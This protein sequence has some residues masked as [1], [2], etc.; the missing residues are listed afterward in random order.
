MNDERK[1]S[2]ERYAEFLRAVCEYLEECGGSATRPEVFSTLQPRLALSEYELSKNNSG[3]ERWRQAIVFAFIGF[4]KAG[5]L[6]RGGGTWRLLDAGREAMHAMSPLE[7]LNSANAKYGEWDDLRIK[8]PDEF[9]SAEDRAQMSGLSDAPG[10]RLWVVGTGT[11][12][13]QWN[14]FR[15]GG[16]VCI[17]FSYGGQQLGDLATMSREAI[18]A[19][20]KDIAGKGN[21]SNDSLACWEFANR[22]REGDMVVARSGV[23]RT[24]GIGRVIGPY[25]FDPSAAD[26]AHRRK[27]EWIDVH[28]RVMP[29]GIRLP[30]KTLTEMSRYPDVV[31]L[32]IGRRSAS[33]VALLETH[34]HDTKAI[35]AFFM[36]VPYDTDDETIE[37]E[38][39]SGAMHDGS[40]S[41]APTIESIEPDWF[42]TRSELESILTALATKRA[43]VLQGSPGTGKTYL[44]QKI[45]HHFAGSMTRVHRVQFHPAYSYED[46]V[47][48]IRP[49]ATGFRVENGPLVRISELAKQAPRQ[50]FVLLIDEMNRGNVAKI[51]GEALSLIEADKRD[52]KHRVQ[53]GLP[54]GDSHDFWIPENVSII[55]TMNTADRSIALVDYALRRR[56]A[57]IR[58]NPAYDSVK[59]SDYLLDQFAPS[60]GEAAPADDRSRGIV[61]AIIDSMREI[62]KVVSAEKSF[63][64]GFAIGHSFFCTFDDRGAE[65]PERWAARVVDHEIRPLIEEY[66]VEHTSLRKKLL[67]LLPRF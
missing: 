57:F 62:N 13:S 26:F 50:R 39:D 9:D 59:F 25:T 61:R 58:L 63:G 49:T 46:F 1:I 14:Q 12:A 55:A 47:R 22:M 29:T 40:E 36:Q 5:Y 19:R 21:P 8:D 32:L 52:P 37:G 38:M 10:L 28:E 54:Y 64:D 11:N 4:Q 23:G 56:F 48:G 66:C 41:D 3:Y 53:L 18:H 17:G 27:V 45:A 6:K 30:I 7:M 15:T 20:M 2:R 33:A 65:A 24:L 42:G 67:E 16:V 44:A 31:D 34:G 43:V 60:D 51:M 35:D